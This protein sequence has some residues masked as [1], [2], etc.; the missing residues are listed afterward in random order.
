MIGRA[1]KKG[2]AQVQRDFTETLMKLREKDAVGRRQEE[3]S[4]RERVPD[5]KTHV[6]SG[7]LRNGAL[8]VKTGEKNNSSRREKISG[9]KK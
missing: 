6:L 8:G 7:N 1:K 3:L 9:N 4:G 5:L 2:E